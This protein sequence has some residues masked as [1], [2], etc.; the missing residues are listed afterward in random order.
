MSATQHAAAELRAF[1]RF[2]T[3]RIG[4]LQEGLL[5]TS[6]SL[7]Q[8]RVLYELNARNG[9][10]A[11]E[12]ARDLG[13]DPGYLS[14]LLGGFKR[15]HWIANIASGGD[16]RRRP[17]ALTKAGHRAFAPLDQRSQMQAAALVGSL[18]SPRSTRLLKALGEVRTLLGDPSFTPGPI[19]MRAH[20]AGD[21]GLVAQRHGALYAQE[22]GWDERFEA[23]VAG[24]LAKF[25]N[26]FKPARERCWIA[27]RDGEFLGCVFLVE[28]DLHTAQLRMLLVEPTARGLGLGKQLVAECI[29]FARSK[30]YKK[31]AL[32]TNSVL[33]AARHIYEAFGFR[34]VKQ[35][36]HRSFGKKLIEQHWEL[37]LVG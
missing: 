18:D 8:A 9:V 27:E 14:R 4:V 19:V 31:M 13:I 28:K 23:L 16:K 5:D 6:L 12:L 24:I 32:W 30:H 33:D 10:V 1:N 2:Y 22:Y 20:R 36:P 37:D 3:R 29:R 17:I 7:S 15:K 34:L 21:I 26:E 35:G 25:V 11:S